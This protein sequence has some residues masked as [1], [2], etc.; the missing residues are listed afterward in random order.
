VGYIFLTFT[1]GKI[2]ETNTCR[3]HYWES[4]MHLHAIANTFAEVDGRTLAIQFKTA[5]E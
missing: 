4:R 5:N 2:S 1:E 3:L